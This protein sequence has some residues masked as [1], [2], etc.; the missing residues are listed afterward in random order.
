MIINLPFENPEWIYEGLDPS[1]FEKAV[2]RV[3]NRAPKQVQEN[4]EALRKFLQDVSS[5]IDGLNMS[6]DGSVQ[7]NRTNIYIT[8]TEIYSGNLISLPEG[9]TVDERTQDIVLTDLDTGFHYYKGRHFIIRD[10]K[11]LEASVMIKRGVRLLFRIWNKKK[12]V[13]RDLLQTTLVAGNVYTINPDLEYIPTINTL[14][15]A[16]DGVIQKDLTIDE[17]KITFGFD[18]EAGRE[19]LLMVI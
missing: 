19:I 14:L 15:V 7:D 17:N 13:F 3:I 18:I 9:M 4:V 6:G 1:L 16:V 11:T 8:S 2:G 12:K 5:K 10:E